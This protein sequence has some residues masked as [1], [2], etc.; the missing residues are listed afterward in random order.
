[1]NICFFSDVHV[2]RLRGGV[3]KVTLLLSEAFCEQ[4]HN[5][6]Q[7]SISQPI[8]NDTLSKNQYVLPDS[9]PY[10]QNN[11]DYLRTFFRE[12]KIDIII[13]QSETLST[14]YLLKE[15]KRGAVLITCIHND[16]ATLI[17]EVNDKWE[18][19][20]IKN[21]IY[22]HILL[23]PYILIRKKIQLYFRQ[24][25]LKEKYKKHYEGSDSIVLLS[26]H[27]IKV[28]KTITQIDNTDKISV[29]SN[30]VS[31]GT[32]PSDIKKKNNIILFVGRLVF[33]KRLDRL[34]K[35]WK[36]VK[37]KE[38][39][40]LLII[41][42]GP[43]KSLFQEINCKLKNENVEFLG[44]QDPRPF[45][46]RAKILCLVSSYEGSPCVIQEA[47]YH[48]VIPLT[49]NSYEA[50]SDYVNNKINGFLIKP[51][52]I[53]KYAETI[54]TLIHNKNL[55]TELQNNIKAEIRCEK[56][57]NE[58]I[59][60]EW[61]KLFYKLLSSNRKIEQRTLPNKQM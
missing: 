29:I 24:K 25:H 40:K 32:H 19:W 2:S 51:F 47:L 17:K 11:I 58:A 31:Q 33:Q 57:V 39:W 35:I 54:S 48:N 49:Y 52:S 5:V 53:N 46:E 3:E 36:A 23:Y 44:L 61:E 38:G 8:G 45:Y 1:M 14:Y 28:F 42:D 56:I 22:K 30:P 27:Y 10:S 13:N 50:A 26:K 21:G 55:I 4:G 6:T 41:G 59:I 9:T 7:I 18:L 60:R 16:P 34:L 20:K 15:T 37:A 12:N 43:D